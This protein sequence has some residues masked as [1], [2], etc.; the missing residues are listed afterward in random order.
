MN[1]AQVCARA[2]GSRELTYLP[3]YL[4]RDDALDG[5]QLERT[6]QV[7]WEWVLRSASG[8]VRNL[9]LETNFWQVVSGTS[10]THECRFMRRSLTWVG[11]HL[12]RSPTSAATSPHGGVPRP[13]RSR[14]QRLSRPTPPA[15]GQ[16]AALRTRVR[17]SLTDA[18]APAATGKRAQTNCTV[19][20]PSRERTKDAHVGCETAT[21][22]PPPSPHRACAPGDHDDRVQ[23]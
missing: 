3:G 9:L 14:R 19:R 1:S 7:Q 2:R 18:P 12:Y 11:L 16:R 4:V 8:A 5:R 23:L 21:R 20:R 15:R 10:L 6:A 22:Q 13:S 17:P